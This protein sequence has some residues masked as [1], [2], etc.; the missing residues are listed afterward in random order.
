MQ[1]ENQLRPEKPDDIY[2]DD[3]PVK[4]KSRG[5]KTQIDDMRLE[6]EQISDNAE[7]RAGY[8]RQLAERELADIF[9]LP[10]SADID[11]PAFE[12]FRNKAAVDQ[13][14]IRDRC[15]MNGRWQLSQKQ[16]FLHRLAKMPLSR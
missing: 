5:R 1:M 14:L 2:I 7:N 8:T 4:G 9:Y 13:Y 11:M 16:Y 3:I 15:P 10:R 6:V 12:M